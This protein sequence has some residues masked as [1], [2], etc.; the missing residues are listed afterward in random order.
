LAAIQALAAGTPVVATRSGGPE[1]I[2]THERD[3]LLV[4]VGD[5]GALAAAIA[6]VRDDAGLR[7]RMMEAGRRTVEDRFSMTAMLDAYQALYDRVTG[8]R[9]A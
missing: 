4:P 9:P 7:A 1:G 5:P 6:R 2:L 8:G 3:G